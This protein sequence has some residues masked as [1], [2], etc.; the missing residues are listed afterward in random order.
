MSRKATSGTCQRRAEPPQRRRRDE[1]HAA[2]NGQEHHRRAEVGLAVHQRHRRLHAGQR[3]EQRSR[4]PNCVLAAGKVPGE[5][6]DDHDSRQLGQLKRERAE[7]QPAPGADHVPPEHGH[8]AQQPERPAVERGR[9]GAEHAVVQQGEG[10]RSGQP[11][12]GVCALVQPLAADRPVGDQGW[13]CES[14]AG[15]TRPAPAR[16][17]EA[18]DRTAAKTG[19]AWPE[20]ART[21]A[22]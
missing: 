9:E 14:P 10:D 2:P 20:P 13:R 12:H 22:R 18:T 7:R 5:T 19:A 16:T 3:D 17:P 21:L 4:L 8:E 6:E 15:R 11:D 1:R